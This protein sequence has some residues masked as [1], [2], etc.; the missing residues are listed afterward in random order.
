MS[1]ANEPDQINTGALAMVI[2]LVTLATL[3]IA[4]YVTSLVREET[5]AIGHVRIETQERGVRQLKAEQLAQLGESPTWIDQ[6]KGLVTMPIDSAMTAVLEAIRR[7]PANLSPGAPLPEGLGG[8]GPEDVDGSAVDGSAVDGSAV[9]GSAA[10]GSA[11]D[12]SAADGGPLDGAVPEGGA[13]SPTG[14]K[15][16]PDGAGM[17]EGPAPTEPVAP[18]DPAAAPGSGASKKDAAPKPPAKPSP[19]AAPS[20]PSPRT[21]PPAPQPND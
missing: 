1:N 11:A 15:G 4:L 14:I 9:D 13:A 18:G 5:R 21:T 17:N 20:P 6:A 7:R 8:A 16:T 10:D 3:A 2:A 12:G 19:G